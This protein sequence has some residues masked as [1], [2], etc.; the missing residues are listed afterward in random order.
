MYLNFLRTANSVIVFDATHF[1]GVA[2]I[3]QV[4]Q[5]GADEIFGLPTAVQDTSLLSK[6]A[7]ENFFSVAQR[8]QFSFL[9]QTAFAPAIALSIARHSSLR[10]R[11]LLA[12]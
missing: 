8:C 9:H 6:S 7:N 1:T 4:D 3:I 10:P 11:P 2:Q 12:E 5:K